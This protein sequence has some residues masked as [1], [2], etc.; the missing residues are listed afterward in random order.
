MHNFLLVNIAQLYLHVLQ[1]FFRY[2]FHKTHCA[3]ALDH[4]NG[5]TDESLEILYDKYYEIENATKVTCEVS[6]NELLEQRSDEKAVLDSIFESGFKE[7][8]P[9]VLWEFKLNLNYLITFFHDDD[10]KISSSRKENIN[11]NNKNNNFRTKKPD[12]CR[13][14]S[15]GSCKFGGKCRFSHEKPEPAIAVVDDMSTNNYDF[16]LEIKFRKN[17]KYPYEP[18]N[19]FLKTTA[20]NEIIPQMSCLHICRRLISEAENLAR[21]GI[22]S[23]Y[24]IV[25]LLQNEEEIISFLKTNTKKF[26]DSFQYLFPVISEEKD[27]L[28]KILPSHYE[29]ASNKDNK[30]MFDMEN[31]L[32]EDI[33]LAKKF[34]EKQNM[35]QYKKMLSERKKLPAWNKMNDILNAIEKSQVFILLLFFIHIHIFTYS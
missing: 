19:I 9:N 15:K 32:K 2:G 7:K 34:I 33:L 29:K 23:I 30:M 25:D 8:E 31:A 4:T 22:P 1:Y 10:V 21:D 14:F 26:I 3:E 24:S 17:T 18:P 13:N 12:I 16:F 11:Y 5:Q 6:S 35:G 20:P 28:K 27:S